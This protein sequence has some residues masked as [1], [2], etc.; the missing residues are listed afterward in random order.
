MAF[1]LFSGGFDTN[2]KGVKTVFVTGGIL[3]SF[4]VL[5]T[6]LLEFLHMVFPLLVDLEAKFVLGVF[7]SV[8]SS[9]R[10]TRR[11]C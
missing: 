6:A 10:P 2:W 3:S 11:R 9:P 7:S 8:R 4:G 1:I 5:L